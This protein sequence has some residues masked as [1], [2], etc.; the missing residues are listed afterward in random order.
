MFDSL[1]I[2]IRPSLT[3]F[4]KKAFFNFEVKEKPVYLDSC[5][6]SVA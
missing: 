2:F 5:K 1:L 6:N 4:L 3:G